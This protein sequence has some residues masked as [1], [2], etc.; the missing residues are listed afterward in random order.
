MHVKRRTSPHLVGD[1][2]AISRRLLRVGGLGDILGGFGGK[3][4]VGEDGGDGARDAV[5]LHL[6]HV[7]E[8]C[9]GNTGDRA[10]ICSRSLRHL[11]EIMTD[12]TCARM[13]TISSRAAWSSAPIALAAL[14]LPKKEPSNSPRYVARDTSWRGLGWGDRGWDCGEGVGGDGA[15]LP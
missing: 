15:P 14:S 5:R 1:L 7:P 10:G 2:D 6:R 8:I 9:P 13:A 12:R 4:A 11:A 3:F